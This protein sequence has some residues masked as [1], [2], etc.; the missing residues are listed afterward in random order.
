MIKIGS[1]C[2]RE[3]ENRLAV[4]KMILCVIEIGS[5]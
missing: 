5:R 4:I 2:D 1:Q 3:V